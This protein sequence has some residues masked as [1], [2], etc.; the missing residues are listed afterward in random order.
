ADVSRHA[1]TWPVAT[2]T[3]A[4]PN[5]TTADFTP[6]L[7]WGDGGTPGGTVAGPTGGPFTVSGTHTYASTGFFTITV[8]IVDD[9]GSTATTSCV[10]LIFGTSVGGNFVIGDGNSAVGTH[11]TFWGAQW[12]KL[13][14][15][16]GGDAPAAFKGFENDRT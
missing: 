13:N 5:A 15:L 8:S 12:A 7:Q 11:V 3:D 1:F 14:T 10:V 2:L 16:S 9:G 4:N 6:T